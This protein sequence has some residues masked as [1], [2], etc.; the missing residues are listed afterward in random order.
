[1]IK[2]KD[3]IKEEP[4]IDLSKEK[5]GTTS[6]DPETGIKTTLSDIN[7][8][9]GKLTWDVQYDVQPQVVI[10]KL[11]DIID[12]LGPAEKDTELSKLKGILDLLKKRIKKLK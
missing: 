5:I 7:P 2:L 4:Y 6:V 11:E 3:I 12:Y 1:M 10:D 9:T 8:E